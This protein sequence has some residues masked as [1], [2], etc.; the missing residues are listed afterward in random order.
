MSSKYYTDLN[1]NYVMYAT[2]STENKTI[3][4]EVL[5]KLSTCTDIWV[6]QSV[7][8]EEIFLALESQ[9]KNP[10]YYGE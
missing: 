8:T 6:V 1:S 9:L 4:V 10:Y 7:D 2:Y 3:E 5:E